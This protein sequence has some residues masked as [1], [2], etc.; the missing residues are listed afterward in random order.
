M[1]V[2]IHIENVYITPDALGFLKDEEP[3]ASVATAA[4]EGLGH[5]GDVDE[6]EVAESQQEVSDTPISEEDQERFQAIAD[7]FTEDEIATTSR[8]NFL[9]NV[10]Y[11]A[12]PARKME[13]FQTNHQRRPRELGAVSTK[14]HGEKEMARESLE[15]ACGECALAPRCRIKGDIDAWLDIH[16]YATGN[17]GVRRPGSRPVKK[18]ESRT[19]FLKVLRSDPLAHCDPAKR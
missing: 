16:P 3:A 1:G 17:P 4:P 15:R 11:H 18:T 6:P 12:S 8:V 10:A 19:T 5:Y 14:Q 7:R 13:G 9:R 2:N